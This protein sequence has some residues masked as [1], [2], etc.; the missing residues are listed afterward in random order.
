MHYIYN[1]I[2]EILFRAEKNGPAFTD[3]LYTCVYI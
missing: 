3:Y 1:Y 2:T